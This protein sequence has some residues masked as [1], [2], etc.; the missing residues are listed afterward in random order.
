[1]KPFVFELEDVLSIRKFEQDQAQIELGKAVSEET[2]I[3]NDL[4]TIANQNVAAKQQ[5]KGQTDFSLIA[6]GEQYFQFLKLQQEHLLEELAQAKIVTDAKREVFKKAMQKVQ[7]LE[8][9]KEEQ[10]KIY[11][12]EE[13][14]ENEDIVDEVMSAKMSRINKKVHQ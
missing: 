10:K 3:Q 12:K 14:K 1:M 5:L 6:Q 2:K 4:E 11:A 9:L 8:K 7:S 13:D